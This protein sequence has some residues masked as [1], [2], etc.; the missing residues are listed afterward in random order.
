MEGMDQNFSQF[1][2]FNFNA[3]FNKIFNNLLSSAEN[4]KIISP[5]EFDFM[6]VLNHFKEAENG[7]TVEYAGKESSAV[8]QTA[9]DS[10]VSS[11]KLLY[12]L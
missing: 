10:G 4:T 7:G 2:D 9:S 6:L 1:L 11:A 12:Y 5:D 8:F 3:N